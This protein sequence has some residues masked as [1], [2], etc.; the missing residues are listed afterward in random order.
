MFTNR[1]SEPFLISRSPSPLYLLSRSEITSARVAP[2]AETVFSPLVTGRR[3][4][5]TDTE[6]LICCSLVAS[7]CCAGASGA[8]DRLQA[9][10]GGSVTIVTDASTLSCNVGSARNDFHRLLGHRAVHDPVRPDLLGI[11]LPGRDQQIVRL[12]FAGVGDVGAARVG[13]GRGVRV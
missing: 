10:V 13:L 7:C 8:G 6:T 5:G 9:V 1:C 2:S 12:R 3:I 4:V 11:R